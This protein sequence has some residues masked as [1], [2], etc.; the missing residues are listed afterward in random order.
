MAKGDCFL[1][2][3]C[4]ILSFLSQG[5][6][7]A[8]MPLGAVAINEKIANFYAKNVFFGGLTYSAHPMCL[9]AGVA[10]L[11]VLQQEDM[12][13]NSKRMGVVMRGLLNQLKV[14]DLGG[15]HDVDSDVFVCRQEKHPCVGDVRSIGL[16]GCLE[17]VK[18]RKTKEVLGPFVG[19]D[20]HVAKMN[21]FI[22]DQGV[23]AFQ[24]KNF[25][26]TNPPLCVTEK[27]CN[28]NK[29]SVVSPLFLCVCLQEL[30]EVF[31]ILD[32]ALYIT[33]EAVTKN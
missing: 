16:F 29:P 32:K 11:R 13:G 5:V 10:N 18:N 27:V 24:W 31:G 25:L 30:K 14:G 12:V 33:D 4:D 26:H 1:F 20:P 2:R 22:K 7:S 6:T 21:A 23:Y 9:A 19:V 28:V 17:L 15:A 3:F 8:Y